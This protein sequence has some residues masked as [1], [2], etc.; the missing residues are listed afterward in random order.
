MTQ[1]ESGLEI[2]IDRG[3]PQQLEKYLNEEYLGLEEQRYATLILCN[4]LFL[5]TQIP[6]HQ[7]LIDL[8]YTI[9]VKG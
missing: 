7:S 2:I 3:Y 9:M 1:T 8:T 4:C 5:S 6:P